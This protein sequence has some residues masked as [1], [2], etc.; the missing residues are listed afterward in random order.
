MKLSLCFDKMANRMSRGYLLD[1]REE[2]VAKNVFSDEDFFCNV[3][4]RRSL[5]LFCKKRIYIY[6]YSI[7][8]NIFGAQNEY[9]FDQFNLDS[10]ICY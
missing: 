8:V 5:L 9:S 4:N 10:V 7:L 1:D 6:E 2:V 3:L